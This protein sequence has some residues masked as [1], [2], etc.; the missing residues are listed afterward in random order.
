MTTAIQLTIIF[1]LLISF[2]ALRF[3]NRSRKVSNNIKRL[4]N[5]QQIEFHFSNIY[6]S[7]ILFANSTEYL[8]SLENE[9]FDPLFE[10]EDE[11]QIGFSEFSL[12]INLENKK[13]NQEQ[14]EKLLIFKS[15]V[16][17]LPTCD[18]TFES[19]EKSTEWKEIKSDANNLLDLL[20]VKTRVYNSA[21]TSIHYV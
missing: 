19:I 2:I 7:L 21:F 6:N 4:T 12:N 18:W 5:E 8:K 1:I 13:I 10:L 20:R 11:F 16:E 17:K 3:Y 15:K 14:L 9:T